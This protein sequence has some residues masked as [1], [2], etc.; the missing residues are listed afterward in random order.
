MSPPSRPPFADLPIDKNGP[1]GNAWGLYGDDDELGALNMITPSTVKAAAQEIQTGDRVSLDWYLNLPSHPSF[2]RPPF[3]WEMKNK[4]HPDGTKRTVNDDHIDMNTQGSSQ[5]DGFRH[6]GYQQAK[7]YYGGRTQQDIETSEVIGIDRITNSG[8]ITARAIILDYPRWLEKQDKP[9]VN[10]L[11]AHSISAEALAAMLHETGIT[12]RSG[13]M[14]L[15][16]TGFTRDYAKLSSSARAAVA[17][18]P[19]NFLGVAST[20]AVCKFIWDHGFVAV[21]SDAPSFEMSPLVGPHNA[22]GGIWKG[23]SWEQDM[24]GGGL[25]HQWL[26]GGWGVMIGELW[27]LERLGDEAVRLGRASC[28]VSSV[29]LKVCSFFSNFLFGPRHYGGS[30]RQEDKQLTDT[31]TDPRRRS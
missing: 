13:D 8:G 21:A 26:L 16:R 1:P 30:V 7:R 10:A 28:F 3:V 5:W 6:Y 14:L 15:L 24:Q 25:L 12:P 23:H 11:E 20:P 31:T 2:N 29:P 22:P 17:T 27:D 4:S 9:P 18:K 19:P